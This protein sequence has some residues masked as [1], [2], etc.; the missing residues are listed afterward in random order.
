MSGS[1]RALAYSRVGYDGQPGRVEQ[2]D[3]THEPHGAQGRDRRRQP[4]PVRPLQRPLRA[5]RPTRTCSP[6][7]WTGWS[8]GSAWQDERLG[9]VVAGAVLK[10]SRDFNLTRESVLGSRLD[11]RHPGVRRPAGLRHRAAGGRSSSPTRSRS[12][13]STSASPAASTPRRD[14]PLGVNED[15]RRDRCWSST[16]PEVARRPAARRSRRL[17][18][19]QLV[20]RTSRATP[21][22]APACPWAST[23]RSPRSEWGIGREAQDELAARRRTSGSPPRTTAGFFDDLV[24]PV[25]RADPRPEPAPGLDRWRSWPSSS[26]SFGR[27]R[28]A[29]DD[30]RQLD[31]ADRRRVDGAAGVARSGRQ[32]RGLPVLAYLD[33]AR[34]RRRRL[35][36]R[37]RGPA[38]GAG[39]RGAADARPRRADACRTSTSTRST[40]RSRRRCW[41][42]W[43]PGRRRTFCKEQLGLD[44]PLGPIDR[45]KLNVN[46]SSLAAGPPVRRDRRPDRGHAGEAARRAGLGPRPDLHLRGRRPGRD[47][48][49]R[50]RVSCPQTARVVHSRPLTY[51]LLSAPR[52]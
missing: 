32:A 45:A 18:P 6:P 10:H 40:R 50:S 11:P 26:R 16:A 25:P 2:A 38:D 12:G 39:V 34:D 20:R 28:D 1:C 31:A 13:R 22:R 36:A 8:P 51:S 17:R 5:R 44:A 42:R 52:R 24:T 30:R 15:L 41:P 48:D 43:P 27:A 29:H 33:D 21:S 7:R 23:P 14:A 37:R 46:G 47:G 3:A 9:E 19:T 49:P 4:D 35:R